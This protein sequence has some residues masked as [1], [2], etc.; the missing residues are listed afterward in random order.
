MIKN[1]SIIQLLVVFLVKSMS[2]SFL[3]VYNLIVKND[4]KICKDN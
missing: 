1:F 4:F 2:K 3:I